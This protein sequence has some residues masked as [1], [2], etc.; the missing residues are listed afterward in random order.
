[1]IV[2]R[3]ILEQWGLE[4][5]DELRADENGLWPAK[6]VTKASL[7]ELRL[8]RGLEVVRRFSP[9][10]IRAKSLANLHRWKSIGSW[11]AVYDEWDRILRDPDDGR[12]FAAMLG[13]G[14]EAIRLRQSA[15]YVGLLPPEL[16]SRMNEEIAG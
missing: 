1:M 15:P 13:R 16:V 4:A 5:G 2:P 14:E 10:E 11:S 9:A 12:L 6:P 3:A 7:D 8:R